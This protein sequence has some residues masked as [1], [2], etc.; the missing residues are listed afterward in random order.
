MTDSIL[1]NYLSEKQLAE[2]LGLNVR[3]VRGWR[4]ERVGPPATFVGQSRDP[5]YRIE[6][7]REWLLAREQPMPRERSSRRATK[8]QP[9]AA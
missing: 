6:A 8:P 4:M 2:Q 1:A 3:T 5:H 7:V 9:S